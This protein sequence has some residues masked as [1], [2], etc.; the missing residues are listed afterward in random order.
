[1]RSISLFILSSLITLSTVFA[2]VIPET[3]DLT[4]KTLTNSQ[5]FKRG[6]PPNAP[7]K[8]YNATTKY[9]KS[10]QITQVYLQAAPLAPP[11]TK[12]GVVKQE[13][14][15]DDTPVT[16]LSWVHFDPSTYKF[17]LV[18]DEV[19]AC[20]FQILGEGTNQPV[21]FSPVDGTTSYLCTSTASSTYG[22]MDTSP[23]T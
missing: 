8:R 9:E 20:P 19:L 7:L 12:R 14:E 4:T 21:A 6:L 22:S 23:F 13:L 15:R 10:A 11:V 16:E 3:S 17:V 5:R 2:S 1:M 18:T